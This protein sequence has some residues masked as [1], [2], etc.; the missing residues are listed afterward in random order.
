MEENKGFG[1]E[2][3]TMATLLGRTM[4]PLSKVEENGVEHNNSLLLNILLEGLTCLY[5]N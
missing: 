5:Y 4:L 2:P 3:N 1:P